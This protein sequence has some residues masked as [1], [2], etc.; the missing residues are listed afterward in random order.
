MH[1]SYPAERAPSELL[2]LQ[3][4]QAEAKFYGCAVWLE[5]RRKLLPAAGTPSLN[6]G[7][8]IRI[9]GHTEPPAS[10]SLSESASHPDCS[11]GLCRIWTRLAL[12]SL[13]YDIVMAGE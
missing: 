13:D 7:H 11:L 2:P 12:L 8:W 9:A 6:G 3:L 10:V 1:T 4:L 5:R